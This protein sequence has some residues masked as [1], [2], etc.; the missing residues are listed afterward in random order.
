[1]AERE[2]KTKAR[3]FEVLISFD[4]LNVGDRFTDEHHGADSMWAPTHVENGYLR[5]VTGEPTPEEVQRGSGEG[6]G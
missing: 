1:M 2:R 3:E 6:Q 5:E 4:G